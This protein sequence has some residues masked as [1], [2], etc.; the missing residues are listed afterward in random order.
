MVILA[1]PVY[2]YSST[3]LFCI[4]WVLLWYGYYFSSMYLFQFYT[5]LCFPKNL[6]LVI[7][8]LLFKQYLSRDI[9]LFLLFVKLLWYGYSFYTSIY[10]FTPVLYYSVFPGYNM[11][12]WSLP[13]LPSVLFLFWCSWRGFLGGFQ[14]CVSSSFAPC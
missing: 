9:L 13:F 3:I 6:F 10:L 14:S 8:T 4:S 5:I 2:I 12:I 11:V 7:S 1:V